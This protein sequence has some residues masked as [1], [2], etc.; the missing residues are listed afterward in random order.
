MKFLFQ[1]ISAL[2]RSWTWTMAWRDSRRSRR[3]LLLYAA[4]IVLGIA[5]LTAIASADRQLPRAIQEQSKAL[6]GADLVVDARGTKL[7]SD[8][9][10]FL[11]SLGGE[12]AREITFGS[13]V[14]FLKS[15][16]T[17][18]VQVRALE[19]DFPFY[20]TLETAPTNAVKA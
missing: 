9:E 12:Q 16:G 18:L 5:A 4:S 19:G 14:R 15:D 11:K 3:R 20:G 8:Q 7:T 17:R 1:L 2:V 6:L 13:M 10:I